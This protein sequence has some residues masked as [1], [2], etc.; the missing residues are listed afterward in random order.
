MSAFH[1]FEDPKELVIYLRNRLIP[2][3]RESGS[4]A[5]ADDFE[6]AC[7]HLEEF[8]A[9]EGNEHQPNKIRIARIFSNNREEIA[10]YL[11]RNYR[12]ASTDDNDGSTIVV[13]TDDHGWT[14]DGY[15]LPR[16]GSGLLAG[17]EIT[18]EFTQ[19]SW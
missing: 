10:Q 16:L 18:D 19:V 2:D 17:K 11:P 3:L 4:E 6:D 12:V 5:T 15:V 14:L 1:N 7:T 8:F 9:A 13:G